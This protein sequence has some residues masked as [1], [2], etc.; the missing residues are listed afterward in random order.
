MTHTVIDYFEKICAI[1]HGSGNTKK[2]AEYCCMIAE[3]NGLF[4]RMDESGNVV[5]KIPSSPGR[6][7]APTVIVQGHLDMVCAKMPECNIDFEKES[8]KLI[9]SGDFISAEGT[10]LGADDGIAVAYA[11]ALMEDKSLVH[12]PIEI[13]LTTDEEVGMT[14][15]ENL[16]VSDL[17]GKMLINIDSDSEGVFTVSCAGGINVHAVFEPKKEMC[18]GSLCKIKADGFKG[19]HSGTEI[20]TGVLNANKVMGSV[21]NALIG[22]MNIHLVSICGGDKSNAIAAYSEAKF[23][24]ADGTEAEAESLIAESF[25]KIKSKAA[26]DPLINI[27]V[28]FKPWFHDNAICIDDSRRIIEFIN[29]VPDGVIAMDG[30]IDGLVKTSLNLGTVR[31]GAD[32]IEMTHSLRSSSNDELKELENKIKVIAQNAQS[33]VFSEGAHPAWEYSGSSRLADIMSGV[34]Y[35][36]YGRKPV[37]SA[38]HAGLECA[39]FADKIKGLD[40]VS[41]GPDMYDIHTVNE[42]VSVSS[43]NRVWD[44]LKDVL[45]EIK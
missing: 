11:L 23:V 32:K 1:P 28:C 27:S 7:D 12:S 8:I 38:I 36:K 17:N 31:S 9:K 26:K 24:L 42:R 19:G 16:D 34:F 3:K 2:L 22:N 14:G 20:N 5:V 39:V 18:S 15:A 41:I 45:A 4:C 21:L 43:V 10:T 25:S 35:G 29:G 33:T 13:V 37:V 6:E 30:Y 40:A 44:F